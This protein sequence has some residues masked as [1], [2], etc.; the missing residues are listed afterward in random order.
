MHEIMNDIVNHHYF[1][2]MILW[3]VL[4]LGVGIAA[5]LLLPS[6]E[7]MG[8]IRTILLGLAGC[9]LGNYLA[10]KIFS[11]PA[12]ATFSW[13]GIAIGIVSALLLVLVNRIVTK[14]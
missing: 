3:V 14:S 5:K 2:Q 10:P 7:N 1:R 12:Y 4:G 11:W 6:S 13:Q 8:W 9:L